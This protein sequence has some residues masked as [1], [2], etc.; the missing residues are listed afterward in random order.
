MWLLSS[1]KNWGP[2]PFEFINGWL[3]HKDGKQ[4]M[5]E[6]WKECK[7]VGWMAHVV[8]EKLKYLK[9]YPPVCAHA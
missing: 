5:E 2:K 1:C 4:F 3:K 7:V 6:K 8:K 9:G